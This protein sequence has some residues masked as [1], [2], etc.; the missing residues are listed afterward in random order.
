MRSRLT[1]LSIAI[2]LFIIL[3]GCASTMPDIASL[4]YSLIMTPTATSN[5]TPEE[6]NEILEKIDTRNR[7]VED[8]PEWIKK[9]Y[10]NL[11]VRQLSNI[12]PGEYKNYQNYLDNGAAYILVHPAFFTFF[13]YSKKKSRDNDPEELYKLNI[14]EH[15]LRKKPAS[16]RF[17]VM[18]AQERRLR[19][20]VE[21]KSTQNKLVILVVPQ[22]YGEY[23]GYT[24]RKG[25]DEYMRFLNEITNFSH[26]VIFVE[27]RSPN[28]GWLNADD[29]IKLMELL[30]SINVDKIYVGGGYIGRCMED[31]YSYISKTYGPDGIFVVPELSDISP[32]EL[33]SRLSTRLLKQDG[34]IDNEYATTLLLEDTYKIQEMIPIIERLQ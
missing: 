18:Q 30:L 15:L 21:F 6:I 23:S 16:A 19:D 22:K 25:A 1:T 28:R 24:Y 3:S 17:A 13:H 11:M 2:F 14:V 26:S 31:F 5:M 4:D 34:L 27:S 10:K 33:N 9:S 12:S 7:T 29:S 32:R 20:F 8:D